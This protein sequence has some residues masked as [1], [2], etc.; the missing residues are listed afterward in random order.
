MAELSSGSVERTYQS[1]A[2]E[3]CTYQSSAP[4]GYTHQSSAPEGC[5]YQ[6]G[7]PE[8]CTYQSSA[9]EGCTYQS[10]APEGCTYQ[11]GQKR[12]PLTYP[13]KGKLPPN[14]PTARPENS[15][16]NS[17][18]PSRE[19]SRAISYSNIQTLIGCS[20]IREFIE[21]PE[22]R[23]EGLGGLVKQG[24]RLGLKAFGSARLGSTSARLGL[25]SAHISACGSAQLGSQLGSTWL[26]ARLSTARGSAH[27]AR[28]ARLTRLTR[29]GSLG[30]VCGS[31]LG[32]EAGLGLN[33]GPRVGLDENGSHGDRFSPG[34]RWRRR[35][36]DDARGT[37]L[38]VSWSGDERRQICCCVRPRRNRKWMG[39]RGGRR[40]LVA[41]TTVDGRG[42][43]DVRLQRATVAGQR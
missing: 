36:A 25:A 34:E 41:S 7:A 15:S 10:S 26:A 31:R 9:P 29:L 19:K 20:N 6:S 4:E 3:G 14:K 33:A 16:V 30:F 28:S 42:G 35:F 39:S 8:G 1:S 21:N 27:S 32:L 5:T 11:S 13:R 22:R 24:V 23:K 37:Q 17:V 2:P 40:W 38:A 12:H 43:N 18:L